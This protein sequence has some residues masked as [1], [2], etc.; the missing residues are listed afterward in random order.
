MIFLLL[1]AWQTMD[2]RG[3]EYVIA[4]LERKGGEKGVAGELLCLENHK[5]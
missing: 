2:V 4:L 3:I 1:G 5:I